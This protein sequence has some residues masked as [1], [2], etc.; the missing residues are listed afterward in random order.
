MR[1]LDALMSA[2]SQNTASAQNELLAGRALELATERLRGLCVCVYVCVCVCMSACVYVCVCVRVCACACV[3]FV[4]ARITRICMY[5][6]M[7]ACMC[8][9][10]TQQCD[11]E[12]E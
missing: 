5:A 3:C 4:Y 1:E 12:S 6:C 7:H 8:I 9:H 11:T 10:L 2:L